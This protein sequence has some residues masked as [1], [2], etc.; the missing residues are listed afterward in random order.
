MEAGFWKKLPGELGE[1]AGALDQ[2]PGH[3]VVSGSLELRLSHLYPEMCEGLALEGSSLRLSFVGL[4]VSCAL[5]PVTYAF[6]PDQ[7]EAVLCLLVLNN[8]FCF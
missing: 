2:V 6:A 7:Y 4:S 3:C 1:A 8:A 5:G